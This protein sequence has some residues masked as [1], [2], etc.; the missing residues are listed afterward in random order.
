MVVSLTKV[1]LKF[2]FSRYYF[3]T[4]SLLPLRNVTEVPSPYERGEGEVF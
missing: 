3:V 4:I 1:W 2:G